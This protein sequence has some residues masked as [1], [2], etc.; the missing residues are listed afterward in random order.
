MDHE[1]LAIMEAL[2]HWHLYLNGK[3]FSVNRDHQPLIYFF[4]QL[5]LSPHQL[6]WAKNL[7]NFLAWYCI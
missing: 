2:Q 6:C 1:M 3:K 4:A 7:A 5:N